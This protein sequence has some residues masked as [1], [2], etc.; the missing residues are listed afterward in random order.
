M[1]IIIISW[2]YSDI[3][4]RHNNKKERKKNYKFRSHFHLNECHLY[5]GPK[6]DATHKVSHTSNTQKKNRSDI[7]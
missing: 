6:K 7:D 2:H 3:I 4:I 1:M 5:A